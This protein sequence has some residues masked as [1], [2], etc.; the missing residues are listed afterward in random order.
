M[1]SLIVWSVRQCMNAL[2]VILRPAV[3]TVSIVPV[4]APCSL[5]P[6]EITFLKNVVGVLRVL[7]MRIASKITSTHEF[8]GAPRSVKS[9]G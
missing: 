8:A 5:V 6:L 3:P 4:L 1:G 7:T 2:N 9:V